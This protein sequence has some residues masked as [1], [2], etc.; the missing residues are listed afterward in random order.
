MPDAVRDVEH[1]V[2]R[3]RRW[4][5][6]RSFRASGTTVVD[7]G[8]LAVYEEGRDQKNAEDEDEGRKLPAMKIGEAVPLRDIAADQHFTEP[9]PRYSE[10]ALVKTLEEYGIGRPSTYASI[11]QVLLNREYVILDSR[12]FKPTD[13]GRAVAK[14]L[15]GH[16]AQYVD[17]DFTAKLEDELDA[18]SRGE[19]DWVPLLEKF[20]K[21]FKAQVD[22]K[23]ETRRSLRGDRRARAR[24][25]S[26]KRQAGAGAP[27]PLRTVRADRHQ[28]RRGQAEVRQP[29]HRPEHAHDHARRRWSCSSCRASSARPRTARRSPSASAASV[30]S[31]STARPTHR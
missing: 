19:E 22:D 25:R 23:N 15:S 24:R 29:A 7:P 13:V 21:P 28:G 9:P 10:A 12:R 5:P 6:I 8:F 31:S 1:R 2:G 14:F 16:F 4:R 18:V 27:R 30:R 20:W 26:E 3:S 17:Y 11:I